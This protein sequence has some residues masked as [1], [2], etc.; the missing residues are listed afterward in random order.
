VSENQKKKWI[1][2]LKNNMKVVGVS[3][4]KLQV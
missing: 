1:D 4:E 2:R 3:E